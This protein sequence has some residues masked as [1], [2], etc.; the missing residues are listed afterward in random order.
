MKTEKSK[1]KLSTKEAKSVLALIEQTIK[2]LDK[3]LDYFFKKRLEYEGYSMQYSED[4][5][6]AISV[7][8]KIARSSNL[9]S[10]ADKVEQ[11]TKELPEVPF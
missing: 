5:R 3:E 2:G 4:K 8:D 1:V 7:Y 6:E 10:Y 11:E 9:L